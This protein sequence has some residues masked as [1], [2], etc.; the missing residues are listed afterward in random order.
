MSIEQDKQLQRFKER[1]Y[2][3]DL[4]PKTKKQQT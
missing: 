1:G 2:Q 4:L 3:A